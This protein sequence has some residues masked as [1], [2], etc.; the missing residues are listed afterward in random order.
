MRCKKFDDETREALQALGFTISD[1]G[2]GA[3]VSGDDDRLAVE[4]VWPAYP[5][6]YADDE[7]SLTIDLPS[8]KSLS[9]TPKRKTL[10]D[11]AAD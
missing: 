11:M 3:T 5:R 2:E 10:I 1:D 9:F 7:F 4:I 6:A 8:G